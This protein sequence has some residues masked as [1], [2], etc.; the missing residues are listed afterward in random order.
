MSSIFPGYDVIAMS[1]KSEVLTLLLLAFVPMSSVYQLSSS[2]QSQIELHAR[3]ARQHFGQ[4][5]SDLAIP[6][7][8]QV[9]AL[10]PGS[11]GE[12]ENGGGRSFQ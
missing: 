1:A 11:A 2:D 7:L 8:K 4:Q 12:A 3:L 6:E 5:H 9:V 10:G